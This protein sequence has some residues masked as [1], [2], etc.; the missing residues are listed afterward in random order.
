[1]GK[2]WKDKNKFDRY[3]YEGASF[4]KKTKKKQLQ[5]DVDFRKNRKEKRNYD[6]K[7]EED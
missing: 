2:T 3:Y 6:D 5:R 7:R 1:M 4:D